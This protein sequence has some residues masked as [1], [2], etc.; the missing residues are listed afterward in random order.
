MTDEEA[1]VIAQKFVSGYIVNELAINKL[2][3]E[4]KDKENLPEY[5]QASLLSV[6]IEKTRVGLL[7]NKLRDHYGDE[8]PKDP[9]DALEWISG[10]VNPVNGMVK[11][12]N[13]TYLSS[14]RN[15]Q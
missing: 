10:N 1:V 15:K 14:K 2:K 4:M 8:F 12:T 13:V 7:Q 11:D 5:L 6:S 9:L 3:E